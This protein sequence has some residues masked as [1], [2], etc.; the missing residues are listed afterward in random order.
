MDW[1]Y[2]DKFETINK[3]YLPDRGEGETKATQIVT[4]IN[5]LVYKWYNDGDVFDNT[6]CMSGWLNDLSS[7]A[8]WLAKHVE[9]ANNILATI[10]NCYIDEDYEQLLVDL[11]D[12]FM[13]ET[14]LEKFNNVP[15]IGTIYNCDGDY[16]FV[17]EW[18]EEDEDDDEDY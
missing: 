13:N 11:A 9:G 14:F 8:N 3:K 7:Y 1:S 18:D 16:Q 4:A 2:F 15:K 6:H 17:E 10:A 5:K 12:S